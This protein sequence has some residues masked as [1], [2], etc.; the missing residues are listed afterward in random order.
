MDV[1][2]EVGGELVIAGGE[3]SAVLEAAEHALDGIA[4]FVEGLAEAAFPAAVG[5]G[6]D[7]GDRALLFDEVADAVAVIG[8][9]GV[10]D[11]ARRQVRQQPYARLAVGR[12]SGRQQEGER[13]PL[14]VGDGMDLG[15][16]SASADADRLGAR[17]PFPPAAERCAFTCVLSISTSAGGPPAAASVSNTARHTPLA[18]QRTLRL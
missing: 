7:V 4:A 12:L 11:A 5:F 15:V 2:E 8:A 17:P 3:A 18:A 6:R 1:A 14:A 16:A 10:D 9:V 13:S